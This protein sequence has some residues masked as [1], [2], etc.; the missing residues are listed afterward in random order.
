MADNIF[1]RK[2]NRKVANNRR[3]VA[4]EP[5]QWSI[6][7][8]AYFF[9]HMH[10]FFRTDEKDS[11]L[12]LFSI[13]GKGV[14]YMWQ[15]ENRKWKFLNRISLSRANNAKMLVKSAVY[16]STDNMLLWHSE[17]QIVNAGGVNGSQKAADSR[18][19]VLMTC[20][21]SLE[22]VEVEV[23]NQRHLKVG[24]TTTLGSF[25]PDNIVIGRFGDRLDTSEVGAFIMGDIM[26][27]NAPNGTTI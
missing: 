10:F 27:I 17:N 5:Q 13:E 21:L 18:T 23:E 9:C 8:A 6:I 12:F 24:Y 14:L 11:P 1:A 19:G 25:P 22:K 7:V 26:G 4:G 3:K 20:E 2:Q 16:L 15:W